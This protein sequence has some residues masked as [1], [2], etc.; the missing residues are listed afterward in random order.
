MKKLLLLL[1]IT[2]S[3]ASY[4]QLTDANFSQAIATCLS[5]NP[6]D[7]MCS[8]SEFG[9]MPDWDVTQVTNMSNAFKDR[10]QFDSN[11]S[12]WDTSN[13][14]NMGGMFNYATSFNQPIGNWD[15]SSVTS[16]SLMFDM[17]TAFNQPIG[18][19]DVSS[20][21]TMSQML[22]VDFNQASAFNQPIGD[23]DVSSVTTMSSMFA[24]ASDFNQS[25]EN[26]DVSSV[27]SMGG[28]FYQSSSFN[29]SLGSWD[30][31]NA[32]TVPSFVNSG[33]TTTNYDSTL[34]GWAELDVLQQDVTV[35]AEDMTY[36][37]GQD[38]RQSLI[39]NYSWEFVDDTLVYC[40]FTNENIQEG[41][42]LWINDPSTA[43]GTYGHISIWDVSGV[44][45]MN[46]LFLYKSSFN[47]NISEWDVSN[48]TEMSRMFDGANL[49]KQDISGWNV[50]NVTDMSSMFF[51]ANL[52]NQDLGNWNISNVSNMNNIFDNSGLS[53]INYDEIL[54]GW[55][56]LDV[57]QNII[58][59][60]Q[61][62]NYCN[63]EDDR[64]SLIAQGWDFIDSG[65]DCSL[66][67]PNLILDGADATEEDIHYSFGLKSGN[68]LNVTKVNL[69]TNTAES[70][71]QCT[72]Y[73][74]GTRIWVF[75]ADRNLEVIN[76][77]CYSVEDWNNSGGI[78]TVTSVPSTVPQIKNIFYNKNDEIIFHNLEGSF[79][80][81]VNNFTDGGQSSLTKFDLTELGFVENIPFLLD[82][83]SLPNIDDVLYMDEIFKLTDI[84]GGDGNTFYVHL[85]KTVTYDADILGFNRIIVQDM[86]GNEQIVNANQYVTLTEIF[87][88]NSVEYL[89][90]S[91]QNS[92]NTISFLVVSD[93][94]DGLYTD[95]I[96]YETSLFI[97]EV[98]L[99][100]LSNV[101][102][103][104]TKSELE[105]PRL[106][107]NGEY[108]GLSS[109]NGFYA[110]VD[111]NNSFVLNMGG[112]GSNNNT[113][114][115][116]LM[117]NYNKLHFLGD[118]GSVV[119]I[120]MD[121]DFQ[122]KW[123]S[124]NPNQSTTSYLLNPW[125]AYN[126][127]NTH[128]II[129]I[130]FTEEYFMTLETTSLQ[131]TD[132]NNQSTYSAGYQMFKLFDYEGNVLRRHIAGNAPFND[133]SLTNYYYEQSGPPSSKGIKNDGANF[134]I[135]SYY[136]S[137]TYWFSNTDSS[138]SVNDNEFDNQS[139]KDMFTLYPNPTSGKIYIKDNYTQLKVV[140]YD[141]LGQ[142]VMK[143]FITNSIDISHLDNGVYILQLS[144]GVKLSTRKI[145]KN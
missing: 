43:Q 20:V 130:S 145:I 119:S 1:A 56:E 9:A 31:S 136:Q 127:Y 98:N 62:I 27:I 47:G 67:L 66:I 22:S 107:V 128:N 110:F 49:F 85:S 109:S 13:V 21:T 78:V 99:S 57:Q 44:T 122:V 90:K 14:I 101:T 126:Q 15:V 3:T 51:S 131:S 111:N 10:T 144:D 64:E 133:D 105:I 59:G 95:G 94:L 33:L 69:D 84:Q 116:N 76:E 65:S 106:I 97:I 139:D 63:G 83:Y 34:I 102:Y 142:Q 36:C 71:C 55:S 19:W 25:L 18:D 120:N 115:T 125:T 88:G 58:L 124:N 61:G 74:F 123:E 32:I 26:W 37:L 39:S 2:F 118:D 138:L 12:A 132:T 117:D 143:K 141:I 75:E 50:S 72:E 129:D 112:G 80:T 30:I 17:A 73:Q 53:Y 5:T 24:R 89:L 104:V 77:R 16:M 46:N 121:N 135:E 38:A 40:Q 96:Q 114:E 87:E 137:S 8:D 103:S 108:V 7:G 60:A 29:Q 79:N 91:K 4:S 41:V 23:W 92:N 100:D 42:D 93:S 81:N 70:P 6:I 82:Y 113:E 28:M 11:I 48:V 45:N 134:F 35:Y 140:V 68:T 54:N 86:N 52:F